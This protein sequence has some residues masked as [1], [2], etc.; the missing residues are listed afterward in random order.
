VL[1]LMVWVLMTIVAK[2]GKYVPLRGSVNNGLIAKA[3][4]VL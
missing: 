3:R 2:G 4:P 1:A